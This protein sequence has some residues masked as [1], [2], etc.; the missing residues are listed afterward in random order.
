[1][2][3]KISLYDLCRVLSAL[4]SPKMYLF[5]FIVV[6]KISLFAYFKLPFCIC[7]H[8]E[9]LIL[10]GHC[11]RKNMRCLEKICQYI[12][13]PS[14]KKTL[15]WLVRPH[16]FCERTQSFSMERER[17]KTLTYIIFPPIS[18]NFFII[19]VSL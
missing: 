5:F 4:Y 2:N 10:M 18:Y 6:V 1:M 13:V 11:D 7:V 12:C 15:C 16:K 17:K 19:T 3:N 9:P 14:K 8:A